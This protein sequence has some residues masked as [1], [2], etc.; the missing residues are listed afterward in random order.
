MISLCETHISKYNKNELVCYINNK[1][2]ILKKTCN[3]RYGM[4]SYK[5][6]IL[7]CENIDI[8]NY[9]SIIHPKISISKQKEN[10]NLQLIKRNNNIFPSNSEYDFLNITLKYNNKLN[11]NKN[12]YNYFKNNVIHN[13]I[14][15]LENTKEDIML[16]FRTKNYNYSYNNLDFYGNL[17]YVKFIFSEEEKYIFGYNI[18]ALDYENKKPIVWEIYINLYY[19][20]YNSG[21]D[22]FKMQN[23]FRHI[24]IHFLGFD[25]NYLRNYASKH[26][27]IL[28]IPYIKLYNTSYTYKLGI[29]IEKFTHK[30][31]YKIINSP[32]F[33]KI[34]EKHKNLGLYNISQIFINSDSHW[35]GLNDTMDEANYKLENFI[36]S[37][38]ILGLLED[39]NLYKVNF[40]N[41]FYLVNKTVSDMVS[42]KSKF[43]TLESVLLNFK[44]NHTLENLNY[45]EIKKELNTGN[46]AIILIA[47][48]KR[49]NKTVILKKAKTSRKLNYDLLLNEIR[50]LS[51]IDHPNIIK[52]IDIVKYYENKTSSYRYILVE[53]YFESNNINKFYSKVSLKD[54]KL[55]MFQILKTLEY[56]KTKGIVL[57]DLHPFNLLINSRLKKLKFIDFG[58]AFHNYEG[59]H[60]FSGLFFLSFP[61][62][63]PVIHKNSINLFY[64]GTI[65]LDMLIIKKPIIFQWY[66][67]PNLFEFKYFLK[68]I[69]IYNSKMTFNMFS[70]FKKHFKSK[71]KS[72]KY[73]LGKKIDVTGEMLTLIKKIYSLEWE[74]FPDIEHILN[75]SFFKEIRNEIKHTGI[76]N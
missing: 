63:I 53:E 44:F 76:N 66:Y 45:F 43:K 16:L 70:S 75:Y 46:T 3:Y 11:S 34:Y 50:I 9:Y 41:Y 48:D 58:W 14:L 25:I 2:N 71:C 39:T 28:E 23:I 54:I 19:I 29:G 5:E 68:Y 62:N 59:S 6:N 69:N 60:S 15:T 73:I 8:L 49:T 72:F 38:F 10:K 37:E 18:L 51:E 1:K 20:W 65:L 7:Y 61:E 26:I 32:N 35:I 56:L 47:L 22:N 30:S 55:Y 57:Y 33:E 24:Y 52:L 40:F 21:L 31:I 74:N 4:L 64:A 17:L 67:V 12:V 36:I 27:Q 42:S 13:I